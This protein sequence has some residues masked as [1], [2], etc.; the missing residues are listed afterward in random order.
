MA[1]APVPNWEIFDLY[2]YYAGNEIHYTFKY[3]NPAQCR[4][5]FRINGQPDKV[6]PRIYQPTPVNN[7]NDPVDP[8]IA[9]DVIVIPF[10][11]ELVVCLVDL[12]N[13]VRAQAGRLLRMGF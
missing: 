3:R 2:A 7:N 1:N 8:Q 12:Q 9:Q 11:P 4:F 6:P 13:A 10:G 5:L